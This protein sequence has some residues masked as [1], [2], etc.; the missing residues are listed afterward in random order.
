[1]CLKLPKQ[2]GNDRRVSF[3]SCSCIPFWHTPLLSASQPVSVSQVLQQSTHLIGCYPLMPT[4]F[5][6]PLHIFLLS[7][8]FSTHSRL[9]EDVVFNHFNHSTICS[10]T[11][12]RHTKHSP[13]VSLLLSSI[14]TTCICLSSHSCQQS[15]SLIF[16]IHSI[17][18]SHLHMS[19]FIA[20]LCTVPPYFSVH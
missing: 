15:K 3:S 14:H 12:N 6:L 9:C 19:L 8:S 5:T 17:Y 13:T 2:G 1:M 4:A 10:S 11:F 7:R 18:M 16:D 20:L